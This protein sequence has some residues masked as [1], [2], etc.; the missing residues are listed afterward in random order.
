MLTSCTKNAEPDLPAIASADTQMEG[1]VH[2]SYASQVNNAASLDS[3]TVTVVNSYEMR[4]SDSTMSAYDLDGMLQVE[5]A[6]QN[7][8]AH[9]T[10]N[11][12]SNGLRFQMEGDY[13]DGR[14]YNT[15]NG[16][17]YYEDMTLTSLQQTLLVPVRPIVIAESMIDQMQGSKDSLGNI[18]YDI[19][20]SKDHCK[21]FFLERYDQYG[22]NQFDDLQVT[23]GLIQDLFDA[24]GQ[25]VSEEATF[26]CTVTLS[27][28]TVDVTYHSL[29]SY[30]Q[31]N[32]TT[33]SI[34]QE[35]KE[36]NN[37]FVAYS[38]ID[39]GK[40]ET[41]TSDDD[42]AENT[43]TATFEKRIVSRLNYEKQEDGTYLARFNNDN[44][45]YLLN[46]KQN[47]FEYSNRTIH[48]IYNWK[49]DTGIM[50]SCTVDFEN[51][52]NS[53]DCVESTVSTI[54]DVKSWLE[55]ELYYC[56]LTLNDLQ[57]ETK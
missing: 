25:F 39:T 3:Y 36:K 47:I 17:S 55:M 51:G 15:Y 37:S 11:I 49:S 54:H 57:A 4:Y 31:M 53:S 56:G 7:P 52:I 20:I 45:S 28:E 38:D 30:V 14:C 46:F 9:I 34:S 43:T 21:E 19:S 5:R 10:Q 18:S 42:A 13:Y 40:I 23:K 22:L 12:N 48:Y 2:E 8:V 26:Q 35:T 41:L 24:D 29:A 33:V 6:K 16:V 27:G 44:E 1:N 32:E 50:G